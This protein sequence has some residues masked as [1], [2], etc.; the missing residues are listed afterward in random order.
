MVVICSI[1]NEDK[2]NMVAS[3]DQFRRPFP[4][5]TSMRAIK[6]NLKRQL[7]VSDGTMVGDTKWE[8]AASVD[9]EK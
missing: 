7:L 3:L 9:M 4:P 2:S 8:P 5:V 6:N 1:E